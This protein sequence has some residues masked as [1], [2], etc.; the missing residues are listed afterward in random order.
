M[1][2]EIRD[3]LVDFVGKKISSLRS[4][5]GHTQYN[6][7]AVIRSNAMRHT[8]NYFWKGSLEK[9]FFC[10]ADPH[11]KKANHRRRIINTGFLSEYAFVMKPGGRIY[12]I[13]DVKDLFD[14]EEEKLN[15]HRLFR[16][17]TK[18]E[19]AADI[20]CAL[21]VDETEEGKKVTRNKGNK[22][23]AAYERLPE[24]N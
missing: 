16:R 10:F 18:E 22:Y 9:M 24:A 13:T 11:F 3:K 6:N 15:E 14:W 12:V 20:C 5:S 21:I 19:E 23:L 8:T 2:I 17:L 7:I 4:E 1:G